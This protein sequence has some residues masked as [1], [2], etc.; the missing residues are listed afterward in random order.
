MWSANAP[1][2]VTALRTMLVASARWN[3]LAGAAVT[4]SVHFPSLSVGDSANADPEPSLLIEPSN[5]GVRVQAPGIPLPDGT[6]T[7][8]LRQKEVNA[9]AIEANARAIAYE[10]SLQNTGLPITG[11]KVG[12]C[13]MPTP[14]AR[15]GQDYSDANALN[16]II[17]TRT[18]PIIFTYGIG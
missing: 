14:A 8:V 6:L 1:P 10:V 4:S 2:E 7:V 3:T 15:A 5:D 13:S 17:A 12:M 11:F 18:I 16:Q 9:D